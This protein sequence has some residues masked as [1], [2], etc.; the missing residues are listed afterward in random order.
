[1]QTCDYTVILRGRSPSAGNVIS[2]TAAIA[3][4]KGDLLQLRIDVEDD[5]DLTD[6]HGQDLFTPCKAFVI[7]HQIP[8]TGFSGLH[9]RALSLQPQS[10]DTPIHG[11][12]KMT[13]RVIR[14]SLHEVKCL[15]VWVPEEWGGPFAFGLVLAD[16]LPVK[17]PLIYSFP[18]VNLT[19]YKPVEVEGIMPG[20]K[21]EVAGHF[22]QTVP[23][24]GGEPMM[25]LQASRVR[26]EDEGHR[27]P[28]LVLLPSQNP[29]LPVLTIIAKP[30][31]VARLT[32]SDR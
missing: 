30:Q 4:G 15:T 8:R 17:T 27:Y 6:C 32:F 16:S 7:G 2:Y 24:S 19:N 9:L 3:G 12:L 31:R 20:M 14:L 11:C 13:G 23:G 18:S 5:Q 1:M 21:L 10:F 22:S 25:V 29:S 28:T 26:C